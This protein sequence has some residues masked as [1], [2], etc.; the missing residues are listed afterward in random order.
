[1]QEEERRGKEKEKKKHGGY[2]EVMGV[3]MRGMGCEQ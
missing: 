2:E 3:A 1:M